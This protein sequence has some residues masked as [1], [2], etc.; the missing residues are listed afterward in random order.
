M[1]VKCRTL[2][3][4][5]VA[6]L[7]SLLIGGQ[8]ALKSEKRLTQGGEGEE[9][10]LSAMLERMSLLDELVSKILDFLG[11]T[12]ASLLSGEALRRTWI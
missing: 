1:N 9:D 12:W 4:T 7:R 5:D 8:S 11:R 6:R 3:Q 2:S 10:D